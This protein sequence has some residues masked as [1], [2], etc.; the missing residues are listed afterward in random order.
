[1]KAVFTEMRRDEDLWL[2]LSRWPPRSTHSCK[3]YHNC[4]YTYNKTVH[5]LCNVI[6][7][8]VHQLEKHKWSRA[9][10]GIG[11]A[12]CVPGDEN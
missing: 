4:F 6:R 10:L 5:V 3:A 8:V 11:I 12:T 7:L 1:M 9:F 2:I